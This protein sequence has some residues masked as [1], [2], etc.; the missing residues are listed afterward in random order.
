MLALE[1][2][3]PAG[4]VRSRQGACAKPMIGDLDQMTCNQGIK[5]KDKSVSWQDQLGGSQ[6]D[7]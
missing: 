2:A 3:V 1:G 7:G 4:W 5:K 6:R